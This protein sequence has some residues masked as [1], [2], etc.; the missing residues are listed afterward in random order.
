[1]NGI[2][3]LDGDDTSPLF[4][5]IPIPILILNKHLEV[6][7]ANWAA[8]RLFHQGARFQQGRLC[9]ETIR[10][11]YQY[12]SGQPCG[13]TEHCSDCV[14]RNSL[15][16]VLLENR[17]VRKRSQIYIQKD[18]FVDEVNVLIAAGPVVVNNIELAMI[19][20]EDLTDLFQLGQILPMCAVCKRVK[21]VDDTWENVE[22]YISRHL[23]S[24]ASHGICPECRK[25]LY[26]DLEDSL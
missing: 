4:Y 21:V 10:C 15:K 25:K 11:F 2:S 16:S 24:D 8:K 13:Q 17:V 20:M 12:E 3:F 14:I 22:A 6:Y 23:G 9:G 19:T 7:D 26:P 5:S 1:M 18:K